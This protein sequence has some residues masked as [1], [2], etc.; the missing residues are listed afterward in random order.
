[1]EFSCQNV[2]RLGKNLSLLFI[3][4]WKFWPVAC[5]FLKTIFCWN[6]YQRFQIHSQQS[7]LKHK[8]F[9]YTKQ[10]Q[11]CQQI[12]KPI[13]TVGHLSINW[14][15]DRAQGE[16]P[17]VQGVLVWFRESCWGRLLVIFLQRFLYMFIKGRILSKLQHRSYP[18]WWGLQ[19][20][21][22]VV[23]PC[24]VCFKFFIFVERTAMASLLSKGEAH[25]VMYVFRLKPLGLT[26]V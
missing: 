18:L 11:S 25:S 8:V 19:T 12:A 7:L 10:K 17:K 5:I 14:L 4:I 24:V 22:F 23:Y 21:Y 15:E 9:D 16:R 20:V 2:Q 1:M 6:R 3:L 26:A 13:F